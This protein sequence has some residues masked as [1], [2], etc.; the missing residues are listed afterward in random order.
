MSGRQGTS[1]ML[2]VLYGLLIAALLVLVVSGARLYG[3]AVDAQNRHENQRGA[4]AYIQS[5]ANGMEAGIALKEGPEGVMLCMAEPDSDFETRIYLYENALRTQLCGKDA[6]LLPEA[7]EKICALT[8]L[9]LSWAS[10]SLLRVCADGR[11]AWIH[12]SG[13]ECIG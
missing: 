1:L 4:L 12:C 10:E 5:Q 8:D 7:G 13:G 3:G 9:S 11:E 6:P 2:L